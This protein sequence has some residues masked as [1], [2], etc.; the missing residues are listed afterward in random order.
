[1]HVDAGRCQLLEASVVGRAAGDVALPPAVGHCATGLIRPLGSVSVVA[2]AGN[3]NKLAG[4]FD[5]YLVS[6]K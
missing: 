3:V 6:S 1:M 5:M 2:P 4:G